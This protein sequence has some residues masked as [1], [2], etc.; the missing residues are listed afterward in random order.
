MKYL[1]VTLTAF[2]LFS[3]VSHNENILTY[4][5]INFE[6]SNISSSEGQVLIAVYNKKEQYT[7]NPFK[8]YKLSKAS[9]KNNVLSLTVKDLP[10]GKYVFTL[11]DDANNNN[12]MDYNWF[13]IPKEGYGFSKNLKPSLTGA[14]KYEDCIIDIQ[15]KT[16][17]KMSM[18]YWD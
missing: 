7:D 18:Q 11:L 12:K 14:P 15:S 3:F 5:E 6:L 10:V 17:I 16:T 1:I 8:T 9:Q 13:G 2:T 4:P